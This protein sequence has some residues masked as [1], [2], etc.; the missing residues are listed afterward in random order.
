M[1]RLQSS[2]RW[3]NCCSTVAL[4]PPNSGGWA[5]NSQPLSKSRRCQLRAHCGMCDTDRGRSSVSASDGRCS[6]R[7]ATN[8]ARNSSTSESKVS[9]IEG[10]VF[11]SYNCAVFGR[12]TEQQLAGLGALQCELKIVLPGEAHRA[13]Q[14]QTVAEHHRLTLPR[15]RLGHRGGQPPSRIVSRNGK[16]RKVRQRAGAFGGNVHIDGLVLNRLESADRHAELLAL[17][18]VFEHQIEDALA[19]ADGGDRHTREC[20]MTGLFC[21]DVQPVGIRHMYAGERDL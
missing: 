7:K 19:R 21:I 5:G 18:H 9:C 15:C 20:N 13:E 17:L 10:P 12:T 16:C 14:L 8:S 11:L 2:S 3:T 4:R 6:S 1:R